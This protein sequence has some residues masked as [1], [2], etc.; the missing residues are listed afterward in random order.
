M[1]YIKLYLN[2]DLSTIHRSLLRRDD[3]SIFD[4]RIHLYH[5]PNV[6]SICSHNYCLFRLQ[7]IYSELCSSS[8]GILLILLINSLSALHAHSDIAMKKVKK[9]KKDIM[10]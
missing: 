6:F 2:S 1:L 3:K 4:Y 5:Y 8:K 7:C 10:A 9:I